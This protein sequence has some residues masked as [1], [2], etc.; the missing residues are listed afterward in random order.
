MFPTTF[1]PSLGVPPAL[2][3]GQPNAILSMVPMLLIL[4]IFWFI[5]VWP[6]MKRQRQLRSAIGA[7][8]RGDKVVTSGGIH[9]E[10]A[11]VDTTI[12][13]L[14]IA[15]GVKIKVAKSGIAGIEETKS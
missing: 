6:Q 2:L 8:K 3:Q 9:G 11:E 1:S 14:K 4:G 15:D 10:V 12:V 13:L 5:V 7:L